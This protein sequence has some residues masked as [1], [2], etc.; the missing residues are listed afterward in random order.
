VAEPLSGP[1][2]R[3]DAQLEAMLERGELL[4]GVVTEQDVVLVFAHLRA[5]LLAASTG[6]EPPSAEEIHRR[7]EAIGRE[8]KARGMVAG[9][10]VLNALEA[11]IRERMRETPR[12]PEL[13]PVR[14]FAPNQN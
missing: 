1:A 9:L 5:V 7:A 3:L 12:R 4:S 6:G 2:A 10:L 13:P 8:L 11:R 14:P